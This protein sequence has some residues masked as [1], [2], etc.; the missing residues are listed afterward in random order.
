MMPLPDDEPIRTSS[1]K[2]GDQAAT[3]ALYVTNQNNQKP[4]PGH[5]F[6]D[7]DNKLSSAG[8]YRYVLLFVPTIKHR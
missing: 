7:S 1:K 6:L 8:A 3:A 2:L 5:E 4:K